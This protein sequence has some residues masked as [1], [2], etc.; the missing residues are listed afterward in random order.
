MYSQSPI[1]VLRLYQ[2]LAPC[3]RIN[4]KKKVKSSRCELRF[5]PL[6]TFITYRLE[7]NQRPPRPATLL[8][9]FPAPDGP[10]FPS[11]W[12]QGRSWP[13]PDFAF[14]PCPFHREQ[15]ACPRLIVQGTFRPV[16]VLNEVFCLLTSKQGSHLAV[17]WL[18][19]PRLA[20]LRVLP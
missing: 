15:R 17:P 19:S 9:V 8:V 10:V 14:P 3:C 7:A 11:A 2:Q 1:E 12:Y 4:C 18:V 6:M 20:L 5:G 13:M 16:E